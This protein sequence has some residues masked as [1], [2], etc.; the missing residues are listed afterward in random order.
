MIFKKKTKDGNS[1]YLFR[2]NLNLRTYPYPFKR[3]GVS[4]DNKRKMEIQEKTEII[5]DEKSLRY[6]NTARRWAM[7]LAVTGFI[8]LGILII[9]GALAGTFMSV[10]RTHKPLEGG[11]PGWIMIAL[12]IILAVLYFFPVSFLFR[13]AKHAG[14]TIET[15][16]R[17]D[18][19][20]A[21]RSLR[22]F[23]VYT[24]ILLI[25]ILALYFT[26]LVI[27]GSSIALMNGL[28]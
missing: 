24:G 8:F 5:I 27:S 15:R 2:K 28:N 12:F 17:N 7:F 21:M 23:F 3:S 11:I 14:N 25:A 1:S 13:F 16:N 19:N 26:A 10:F 4:L 9:A 22:S 20:K 18:L 6:L